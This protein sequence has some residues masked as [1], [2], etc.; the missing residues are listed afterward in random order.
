MLQASKVFWP[1]FQVPA[2]GYGKESLGENA[3]KVTLYKFSMVDAGCL[4]KTFQ[5]DS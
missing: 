3:G 4:A 2:R 5:Y 1:K